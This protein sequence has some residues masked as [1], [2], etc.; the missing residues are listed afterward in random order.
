MASST[1]ANEIML[2]LQ[3]LL[4]RE[5]ATRILGTAGI[6]VVLLLW[7]YYRFVKSPDL[8]F[9]PRAGKAPGLFGLG[10][11]D[12]K[13]DF[14]KNGTK[15]INDGYRQVGFLRRSGLHGGA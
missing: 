14:A 7:A 10:L 3:E 9:I 6:T 12:V 15:I 13:R 2:K 5:D 8:S 1:T 11:N 4:E